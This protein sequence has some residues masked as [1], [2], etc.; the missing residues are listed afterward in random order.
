[1]SIHLNASGK[2]FLEELDLSQEGFAVLR[3]VSRQYA[4]RTVEDFLQ[5]E[6]E[7]TRL[8]QTLVAI[9][10]DSSRAMAERL[11]KFS[12]QA[13]GIT[14]AV[15]VDVSFANVNAKPYGQLFAEN[16]EL[17]IFS[18]APLDFEHTGYWE[19]LCS[20]FLDRDD[21][22]LV[23]FVPKLEIANQLV[24]RFETE[25]LS[26]LYDADGKKREDVQGFGATIFVIVTNL[27]VMMPYVVIANPGSANLRREGMASSGWTVGD[28][29][30]DFY[31]ISSR[32]SEQVIQ[33]V[34]A[35]GLGLARISE[36]FFPMG[37]PLDSGSG[38]PFR[39]YPHLDLLIA[40]FHENPVG[41]FDGELVLKSG[42]DMVGISEH[43]A[44]H[45]LKLYPI[46]VRAY[47]KKSRDTT[48]KIKQPIAKKTSFFNRFNR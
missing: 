15:G 26:R 8:Y 17:W 48:I 22:M 7:I 12:A 38:V 13:L 42:E 31:Q 43:P 45:P 44:D 5:D 40:T 9:G 30:Q 39:N 11:R 33:Q 6:A 14:I 20:E 23:Y 18:S 35:A 21:R 29:A 46:F 19:K 10:S 2:N 1:M 25:L 3:G 32:F 36:N 47:R 16:K 4:M 34:R 37:E 27:A 24:L 41:L 28:G